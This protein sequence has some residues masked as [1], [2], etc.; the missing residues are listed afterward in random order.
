MEDLIGLLAISLG[1]MIAVTL[2]WSINHSVWWMMIHGVLNWV[3]VAYYI[4]FV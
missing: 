4:I 3:Y 1:A 2:S